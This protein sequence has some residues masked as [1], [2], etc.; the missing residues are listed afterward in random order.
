MYE[1]EIHH[2]ED[3]LLYAIERIRP[4]HRLDIPYY[5]GVEGIHLLLRI[6]EE[7]RLFVWKSVV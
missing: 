2:F 1:M 4:H 7:R 5:P 3:K 6:L